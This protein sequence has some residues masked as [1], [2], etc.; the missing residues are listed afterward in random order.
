MQL[1][2]DVLE[3]LARLKSE[4]VK[5][6]TCACG[7]D[8]V[9]DIVLDPFGGSGTTAEVALKHGRRAVLIELNPQYVELQKARLGRV[10]MATA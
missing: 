10:Q 5:V 6:R 1:Q 9:P 7:V 4:G 2:G 3:Q 8:P